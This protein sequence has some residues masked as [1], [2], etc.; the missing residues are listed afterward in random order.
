MNRPDLDWGQYEEHRHTL[1]RYMDTIPIHLTVD[2]VPSRL[3][4]D[5][6]ASA[7]SV[8]PRPMFELLPDGS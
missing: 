4:Y 1:G 7:Q 2:G 5:P 8:Q 3:K 6:E